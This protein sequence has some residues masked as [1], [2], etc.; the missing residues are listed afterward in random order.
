MIKTYPEFIDVVK[1]KINLYAQIP[2]SHLTVEGNKVYELYRLVNFL[3]CFASGAADLLAMLDE[4][5]EVEA[6]ASYTGSELRKVRRCL[7]SLA[8][9]E[10]PTT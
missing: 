5:K 4:E 2:E 8:A 9:A 3:A 1:S 10:N 7:E 6:V